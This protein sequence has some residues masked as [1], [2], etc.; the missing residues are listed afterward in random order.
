MLKIYDQI[1]DSESFLKEWIISQN[2]EE[3]YLK[4]I[5]DQKQSIVAVYGNV[6]KGKTF[7]LSRLFNRDFPS[8][9]YVRTP[10][11]CI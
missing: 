10:G 4:K 1:I 11:I 5:L 8:Q 7:V 3:N 9:Y 6:D 2:L